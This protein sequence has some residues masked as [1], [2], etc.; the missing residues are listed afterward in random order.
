M[1]DSLLKISHKLE[2]VSIN[3]TFLEINESNIILSNGVQVLVIIPNNDDRYFLS[4]VE[5]ASFP[6]MYLTH[7]LTFNSNVY[8]CLTSPLISRSDLST[9]KYINVINFLIDWLK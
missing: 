8:S 6:E 4:F 7:K 1:I 3:P 2:E 9:I 5:W